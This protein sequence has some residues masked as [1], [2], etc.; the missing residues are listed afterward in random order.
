MNIVVRMS[1]RERQAALAVSAGILEADCLTRFG[2]AERAIGASRQ[3]PRQTRADDDSYIGFR[4]CECVSRLA[5]GSGL[6]FK[7]DGCVYTNL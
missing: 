1:F 7:C 6:G 5:E 3:W 2:G 4:V